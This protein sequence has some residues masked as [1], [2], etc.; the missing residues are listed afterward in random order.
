ML[1]A[2]FDMT[3]VDDANVKDAGS[4]HPLPEGHPPLHTLAGVMGLL[5]TDR[6]NLAA[7]LGKLNWDT[8]HR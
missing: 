3:K 2:I 6:N 4:V 5:N 8:F 7:E 1:W